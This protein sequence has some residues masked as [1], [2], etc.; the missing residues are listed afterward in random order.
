[1]FTSRN[2]LRDA[3]SGGL[4][5]NPAGGVWEVGAEN[6]RAGARR[7]QAFASGY[8]SA[9]LSGGQVRPAPTDTWDRRTDPRH[10]R[11]DCCLSGQIVSMS[12]RHQCCVDGGRASVAP[13]MSNSLAS[14]TGGCDTMRHRMC[15]DS[16]GKRKT[17][18]GI[19]CKS[20][21]GVRS[22]T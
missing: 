21:I 8:G 6:V 10:Q 7:A 1:M 11:P 19:R 9:D 22:Q 3:V 20:L 12:D 5:P 15:M 17:A 14:F 13:S 2:L 4:R 16:F 18:G